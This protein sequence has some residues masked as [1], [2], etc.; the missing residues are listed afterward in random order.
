[1]E[2]KYIIT[3]APGTGKTSI[4]NELKKRGYE[5]S[6]EISRNIIIEQ[7]KKKGKSLP[8]E[9]LT[10]FSLKVFNKRL[11]QFKNA[12]KNKIHFFDRSIIDVIAYMRI[13]NLNTSSFIFQTKNIKYN[14]TVFYTPIWEDI[15]I[16]DNERKEDIKTAIK[17]E[18]K[19][20]KT[21][22]EFNYNMINIP[23]ISVKE[24]ANFILSEI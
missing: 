21:Y 1:M 10:S 3:G 4:I 13:K 12:N 17:I 23:K 24:R 6:E 8:W 22:Q 7:L 11:N 9:D 5:C 20:I 19:I 15:Y 14:K 16:N 18:K 2:K